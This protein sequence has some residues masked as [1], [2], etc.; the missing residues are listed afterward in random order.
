MKQDAIIEELHQI[1]EDYAR[2]FNFD[3][4]AICK[5]IQEKQAASGREIVS[6]SPRKPMQQH[7]PRRQRGKA[8]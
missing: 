3:T 8:Q 6:F 4:N 2:K 5:D 1:R 7:S